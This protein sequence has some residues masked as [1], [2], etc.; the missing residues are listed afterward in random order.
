M[1]SVSPGR[2]RLKGNE[3]VEFDIEELQTGLS[4]RDAQNMGR[5]SGLNGQVFAAAPVPVG[6]LHV[7]ATGKQKTS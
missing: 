5:G 1:A 3:A 6:R 4:R 2:T 7:P